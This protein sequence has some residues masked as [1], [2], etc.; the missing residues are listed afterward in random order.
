MVLFFFSFFIFFSMLVFN[1]PISQ[2]IK[3]SQELTPSANNSI[4][5]VWPI[6]AKA[7]GQSQATITVFLRNENNYPV[8]DKSVSITSTVGR[9]KEAEITTDKSGK[10]EFHLIS[11]TPGTAKIVASSGSL[12]LTEKISVKFE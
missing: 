5:L 7:D 9:I 2:L 3:A 1:K 4:V 11:D 6:N 10:A 8:S 12:E